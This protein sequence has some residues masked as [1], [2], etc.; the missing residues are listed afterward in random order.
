MLNGVILRMISSLCACLT[1]F[2]LDIKYT[3]NFHLHLVA[4]PSIAF[5]VFVYVYV[6]KHLKIG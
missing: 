1:V 6:C 2:V 3:T 5:S 4:L